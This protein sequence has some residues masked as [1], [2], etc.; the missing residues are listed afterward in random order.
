[1]EAEAAFIRTD[2]AVHLDAE[3]AI[4]L[5][6]AL[7]VEPGD[8]KHQDAFGLGDTFEDFSFLVFGMAFQHKAQRLE[9]FQNS[10]VEFGLCRVLGF[11]EVEDLSNVVSRSVRHRRF[12][13]R[14]HALASVWAEVRLLRGRGFDNC[15]VGRHLL[16]LGHSTYYE[17]P[18]TRNQQTAKVHYG[19][20]RVL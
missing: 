17:Q 5:G 8:A 4:D 1:M 7:V 12:H 3:S 15:D 14:V 20:G 16:T 9:Y 11:D 6:F 13:Y 2:S 19:V 18:A 10:L